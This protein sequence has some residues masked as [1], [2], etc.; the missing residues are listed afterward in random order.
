I[1]TP[2]SP[3][4][5]PKKSK[6]KRAASGGNEN[7]PSGSSRPMI[8]LAKRARPATALPKPSNGNRAPTRSDEEKMDNILVA[9]KAQNWT[10]SSFLFRVFCRQ[11]KNGKPVKRSTTHSQMVSKFLG[12][13]T[14]DSVSDIIT[15]W[16]ASPDGRIAANSP[17]RELLYSTTV[18]YTQ[19]KPVRA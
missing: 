13:H 1:R 4:S 3:F 19:I 5:P 16:M 7:T 2:D 18:P 14:T 6:R 17:N 10:F 15:E 11:D 9:I 12:G 8:P